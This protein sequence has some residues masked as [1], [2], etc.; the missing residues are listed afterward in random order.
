MMID[1]TF[2]E[3]EFLKIARANARRARRVMRQMGIA[4]P[5]KLKKKASKQS[6]KGG[7]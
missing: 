4:P 2:D 1:L 7:K 3:D 5:K 6:K